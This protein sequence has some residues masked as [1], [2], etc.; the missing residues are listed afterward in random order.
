MLRQYLLPD[1][2][3]G[4][5][6][7]EIVAWR[8]AVGDVIEV[9]DVLVEIETAK[10]LVELPSPYAGTVT[11]LLVAEGT[12]VDIGTPVVEIEDG[13]PAEATPAIPPQDDADDADEAPGPNLVGY[14]ASDTPSTRRRR[15]HQSSPSEVNQTSEA[16]SAAYGQHEPGRRP[17]E[18]HPAEAVHAQAT[19]DPLPTP[20]TAPS[21]STLVLASDPGDSKAKPPVRKYAK[22]LGVDLSTVVGTG[23]DG[24]VT[25]RDV[26]A[27]AAFSFLD[28][29]PRQGRII[30]D[31]AS[32]QGTPRDSHTANGG[33]FGPTEGL[34]GFDPF[35][36][37]SERRVPIKGV[38]KVTA[39]NM[40]RSVSTKVHVTEWITVDVTGMMDFV[41]TLKERREFA[42]LRVSPLL[43]YA[44]A[45]CLA[46]GRNPDLNTSWDADTHEIVY[47]ADVN[48]GI[49]AATPRGLM[50]PNIKGAQRLGLLQLCQAINQLVQ[51]SREGKLQ[52][53]DYARGTFTITNVGV[54]GIDAGTPIING[55][56]SAI[57]CMGAIQRRPWVV[58][59]GHNERVEPRWVTTLAV[60]FDHRIID[61]EQGSRF[62][63]DVASI[64]AEPALALL[65]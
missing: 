13:A 2:G 51:V 5:L 32:F 29:Q 24:T 62:L 27:A 43:V 59:E 52:P 11:A 31:Q 8:V 41:E 35:Q 1:P 23:P 18:V 30:N 14:G 55:N 54:F 3:E 7:A 21:E 64:L 63:H 38:R 44:K 26:E 60:A 36:G 6:E 65:Y 49:A 12:T 25:R 33:G 28:E 42:G 19:G 57:F 22:D 47:H 53:G 40:V 37:R 50:V 39:E 16:L 48:L 10:S 45:I 15:R 58:G 34:G 20:G 46:L 9:N 4:L 17:D 56:E 61:G